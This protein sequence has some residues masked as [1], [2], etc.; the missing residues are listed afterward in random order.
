M[1]EETLSSFWRRKRSIDHAIALRDLQLELTYLARLIL[2]D[3]RINVAWHPSLV[4][5]SGQTIILDST[6]VD[7]ID[8]GAA[9]PDERVDVLV[10]DTVYRSHL[11]GLERDAA[12]GA[13]TR[14]LDATN[15]PTVGRQARVLSTV[16]HLRAYWIALNSS[17]AVR[18]YIDTSKEW[19]KEH[20]KALSDELVAACSEDEVSYQDV[21][22]LWSLYL[23]YGVDLSGI[24][25]KTVVKAMVDASR[26][27]YKVV[28]DG[29]QTYAD[30]IKKVS[31][32][33]G[34]FVGFKDKAEMPQPMPMPQAG[35]QGGKS[36]IPGPQDS[37]GNSGSGNTFSGTGTVNASP[38]P[39]QANPV[40]IRKQAESR[41]MVDALDHLNS[42]DQKDAE[43]IRESIEFSSEDITDEVYPPGSRG[44]YSAGKVIWEKAPYDQH[45][46]TK[47]RSQAMQA[48][49]GITQILQRF[50][51][52]RSRVEHGTPDGFKVDGRRV[53]RI[54]YGNEHVFQKRTVI[55]QLDMALVLLLDSSGSINEDSWNIIMQ[56]AAAFVQALSHRED[57]ELIVASYT[58]G[59]SRRLRLGGT[60][61]ERH[62]DKRMGKLHAKRS[63]KGGT[64]SGIA[65]AA[66]RESI[67]KRLKVR[68]RDKIVIHLTDGSPN[69]DQNVQQEV[70]LNKK[71]G[72]DTFC[73]LVSAYD[74]SYRQAEFREAYGSNFR[75][76]NS[77]SELLKCLT[78][79]FGKLTEER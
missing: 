6:P 54:M 13:A 33:S 18:D 11:E 14:I 52:M 5:G 39:R 15:D 10:G 77:Y 58:D 2:K 62:Y 69:D 48:S 61:V 75:Y 20:I 9:V 26:E 57:V 17:A 35:G 60:M 74:S 4:E 27:A 47:L 67:F 36:G 8:D 30:L 28:Q 71:A 21:I 59:A 16:K 50:K 78:D 46:E 32:I 40:E 1:N 49:A 66:I 38:K 53:G 37:D 70:A 41:P 73:I 12:Y 65:L 3:Q 29:R 79:L 56:T 76:L 51:R 19:K 34:N 31:S 22:D 44:H 42:I 68:K 25:N 45:L 55:D 23:T 64:P 24:H 63:F 43:D 72:I 7:D